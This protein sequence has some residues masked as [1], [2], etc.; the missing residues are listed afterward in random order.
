[1]PPI[2]SRSIV[3]YT[4]LFRSGD[5]VRELESVPPTSMP[6][7]GAQE[8]PVLVFPGQ[9]GQ[10]EG[11]ARDLLDGDGPLAQVFTRRLLECERALDRSEEHTSELQSR[12]DLV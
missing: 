1:L 8:K 4:T 7:E 6:A 5:A 9:G 3:P 10:W 12:Y 11:M 2:T